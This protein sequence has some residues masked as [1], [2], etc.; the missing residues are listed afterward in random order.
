MTLF[1]DA[2]SA[3]LDTSIIGKGQENGYL[4]INYHNIRD[5]TTNRQKQVDDYPYGGGFG[6]VMQAQPICDC[7]KAICQQIGEKPYVVYLSPRGKVFN[8]KKAIELLEKKNLTLLC[9]HY[10]GVDE[11]AIELIVDEEISLGDF[12]MTGGEIGAAAIVDT[13]AR[14]IDGVLADEECYTEE[15][16]FNGLLEH[17]QYSRPAQYEGKQVPAVLQSGDH[18]K[19][20]KW[21]R[22]KSLEVTLARRV[23]MILSA[24]LSND[25]LLYLKE[26]VKDKNNIKHLTPQEKRKLTLLLKKAVE[27][28]QKNKKKKKN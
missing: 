19:I 21:R 7:Y 17:P 5:Y 13:V 4:S 8:Q 3:M 1:T 16:H 27:K 6:M 20:A 14:M 11:R 15:S 26:Y 23:D 9:G 12:V 22:E 2:V 24:P 18:G 25:D 28:P 10:E